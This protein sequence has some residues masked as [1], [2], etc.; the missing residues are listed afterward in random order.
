MNI[1]NKGKF[2]LF[3]E[4]IKEFLVSPKPRPRRDW[5]FMLSFFFIFLFFLIV[6]NASLFFYWGNVYDEEQV[7][8]DTSFEGDILFEDKKVNLDKEKIDHVWNFFK[9]KETDFNKIEKNWSI[10]SPSLKEAL[11]TEGEEE[12]ENNQNNEESENK[13]S[14]EDISVEILF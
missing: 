6:V 7:L 1:K 3:K 2:R 14:D 8:T 11:L 5:T 9:D 12:L 13:E 10:K 4:S